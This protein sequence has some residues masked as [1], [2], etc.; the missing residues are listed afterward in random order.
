MDSGEEPYIEALFDR[1]KEVHDQMVSDV[2]AAER[3]CV[4]VIPPTALHQLHIK[5]FLLEE[6]FL[7]RN[8]DRCFAGQ[9]D[10]AHPDLIRVR[11]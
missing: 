4:F 10:V 11:S 8:I 7:V 3:E 1:L 9:A 6:A 2:V 5:A